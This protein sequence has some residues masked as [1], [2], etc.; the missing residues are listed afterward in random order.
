MWHKRNFISVAMVTVYLMSY[1]LVLNFKSYCWLFCTAKVLIY[2]NN[3]V[4][5]LSFGCF[6][7]VINVQKCHY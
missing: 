3:V 5:N 6:S 4:Y 2:H 1:E 7:V